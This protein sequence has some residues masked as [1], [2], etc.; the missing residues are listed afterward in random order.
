MGA[1]RPH[2]VSSRVRPRSG[3]LNP[4]CSLGRWGSGSGAVRAGPRGLC[5]CETDMSV[6]VSPG[7]ALRCALCTA[8]P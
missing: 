4:A 7:I 8:T 2:P 5:W 3:S 6:T 1:V